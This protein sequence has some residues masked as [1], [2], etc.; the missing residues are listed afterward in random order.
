MVLGVL[1][2]VVV[3]SVL[4]GFVVAASVGNAP[5]SEFTADDNW[6]AVLNISGTVA[7]GGAPKNL[8]GSHIRIFGIRPGCTGRF[9][10][11][12]PTGKNCD[13]GEQKIPPPDE[14]KAYFY[15]PN[16]PPNFLVDSTNLKTSRR[17]ILKKCVNSQ[18]VY[19][20]SEQHG[21]KAQERR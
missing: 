10:L 6:T 12:S 5:Q 19:P 16:N 9:E 11:L 21:L 3:T 18:A 13:A 1:A 20:L 8:T 14:L 15:Y 4:I 7:T 2:G 17:G